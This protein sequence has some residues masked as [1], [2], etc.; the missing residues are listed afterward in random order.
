M[1]IMLVFMLYEFI[2]EYIEE[3][4]LYSMFFMVREVAKIIIGVVAKI[5]VSIGVTVVI[6]SIYQ[7]IYDYFSQEDYGDSCPIDLLKTEASCKKGKTAED[8]YEAVGKYIDE[9]GHYTN[10][11]KA[12]AC[13]KLAAKGGHSRAKFD[14]AKIFFEQ[15]ELAKANACILDAAKGGDHDSVHIVAS[16]YYNKKDY[17]N[18]K[19]HLE[20]LPKDNTVSVY[21]RGAIDI[22]EGKCESGIKL[23]ERV[24]DK[25][26]VI[27]IK[28]LADL[29]L[30]GE[31]VTQDFCHAEQYLQKIK[32][33][34]EA[35]QTLSSISNCEFKAI[36]ESAA[37]QLH[38]YIG[39]K[40][41]LDCT[42]Y[43]Y[44]V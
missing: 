43:D 16:H 4:M 42:N 31:C 1:D 23:L 37:D 29:Y 33:D 24:A 40:C 11:K 25:G 38:K 8:D 30:K 20:V 36:S 17:S 3:T 35:E 26:L 22:K 14:I 2:K 41:S 19:K 10:V 7:K 34:Q 9:K 32:G 21:W 27:A 15:Q 5:I 13:L 18:A 12:Y 44:E 39:G 6:V 28:D